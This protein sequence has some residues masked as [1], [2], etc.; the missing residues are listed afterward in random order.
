MTKRHAGDRLVLIVEDEVLIALDIEDALVA[1]GFTCAVAMDPSDVEALPL[2][3]FVVAVIDLQ[4]RGCLAG[5]SVIRNLRKRIPHLPVVV[6]T[7][8]DLLCPEADLRGLG[9]PTGRL[10]KPVA[11]SELSQAVW[12]VID[13]GRIGATPSQRLR[14]NDQGPASLL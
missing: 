8:F 1:E 12:E 3:N 4:L 6:L 2:D 11:P 14:R 9:G 7:G 13:R 5:Q 10:R